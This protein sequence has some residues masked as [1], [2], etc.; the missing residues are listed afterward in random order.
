MSEALHSGDIA[1]SE[2]Y[3]TINTLDKKKTTTTPIQTL[4]SSSLKRNCLENVLR[5]NCTFSKSFP[6]FL[7]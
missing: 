7:G 4:T 5:K 1:I 3:S 2:Q 6:S